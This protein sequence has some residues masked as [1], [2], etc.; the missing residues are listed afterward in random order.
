MNTT[1]LY[2]ENAYTQQFQAQVTACQEGKNGWLV[3]LD[4]TAFFP[5]GGGQ[6]ADTGTLGGVRVLDCHEKA[7]QILHL[8]EGPLPVG[9]TVTGQI[10]WHDRFRKMQNHTGEHIVSGLAHAR[11]GYE[12]VGFHLA[13]DG[14]TFDFDGE[15][16]RQQ[17]DELE[18]AA[19]AVVWEN[20]AVTTAFPP[21]EALKALTYRSK[22]D[23]TE[24]VRLVTVEGIDVCAC[25]A[26]HVSRTGEVGIIKLLDFMRHRG[27]VRIWAKCGWDALRDYGR[28]YTDSAA[29]SG[30]LNTPQENITAG[31]EKL[32]AQRDSLKQELA[33]LQRQALE[34]QAA[35]LA[36][37]AGHML[38]F[39][40]ADNDGMRILANAGMAKC[41]RVCA[42]FSGQDG[43]YQFV[44]A[45]T[46]VDMR[47]FLKENQT[48]LQA[49]GGGQTQMV[50]G[51]STATKA[52]L[53]AFFGV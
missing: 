19:N 13:E 43:A 10:D 21:P 31:V 1:K 35:S 5:E 8:T 45:S 3:Q 53:E 16:T 44:M 26:P 42:V 24:N 32:L 11:Y 20:R 2:Y 28:R 47:A 49:R 12:N 38:L 34:A 46:G 37:T 14:C 15:L 41:G 18:Q 23:L 6:T 48:V 4:K 9:Q 52:A 29:I 39:C 30:L 7:G 25:C 40:Q 51:R 36:P 33:A 17:L 50:S 22:L 27:G